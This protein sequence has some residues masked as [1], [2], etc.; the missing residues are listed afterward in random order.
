[1]SETISVWAYTSTPAPGGGRFGSGIHGVGEMWSDSLFDGWCVGARGD[2]AARTNLGLVNRGTT[3]LTIRYR[4]VST[5]GNYENTVVVP[6]AGVVQIALNPGFSYT[7]GMVRLFA[8][9]SNSGWI[10]YI[11]VADNITNDFNFQYSTGW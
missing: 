8:E 3:P 1:M 7:T 11:A 5:S 10:G 4:L 2:G 9:S 6:A